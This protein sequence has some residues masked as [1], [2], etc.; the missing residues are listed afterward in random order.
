MDAGSQALSE[1]L[2]SSFNIVRF[3]LGILIVVFIFSGSFQVNQQEMAIKLHFGKPVGT[4]E[5]ALIGPGI[6]WAFPYPIDE[7]VKVPIKGAQQVDSTVGWY[8]T[9]KVMEAAGTEPYAGPT[10]NPA[11]DGY[12]LT[13]D[14]NIIHTRA[15]LTYKIIDPVRYIF[16]FTNAAVAVQNALDNALIDA[17]AHFTVDDILTRDVIGFNDA[18]RKR[19]SDLVEKHDLG[20]SVEQCTVQSIAPRQTKEAF[21]NVLKAELNRSKLLNDARSYENQITNRAGADA[22]SRVNFAESDRA[23]LISDVAARASQFQE[24]L[25]RY[26]AN[27]RLFTEQRLADVMGRVMTNA[28]EKIFLDTTSDGKLTELRLLLNREL[29]KQKTEE[30]KP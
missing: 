4:G 8:A 15:T 3:A 17:A 26:E 11:V 12:A 18:V 16:N 23:R 30:A 10:L 27:P 14:G 6:H 20:V 5:G 25:P 21:A 28:Q 19:A 22:V 29:P 9:T 2:R 1:A 24:L 7:I 13:A